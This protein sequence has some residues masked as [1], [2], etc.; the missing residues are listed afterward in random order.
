MRFTLSSKASSKVERFLVLSSSQ[1]VLSATA[2]ET[3][4]QVP[5]DPPVAI[6]ARRNNQGSLECRVEVFFQL[7][8]GI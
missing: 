2:E 6:R 1:M 8:L 4:T 7:L 3:V 5:I